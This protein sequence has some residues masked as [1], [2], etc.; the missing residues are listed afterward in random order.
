M[1]RA[2]S[3]PDDIL[4]QYSSLFP[5]T[6]KTKLIADPVNSQLSSFN[7]PHSALRS[8]AHTAMGTHSRGMTYWISGW[9]LA[10]VRPKPSTSMRLVSGGKEAS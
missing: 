10:S 1:I 5:K 7:S 3:E 2:A 9:F 6:Q 8:L 4:S